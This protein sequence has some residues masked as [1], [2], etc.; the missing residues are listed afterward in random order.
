MQITENA[1]ETLIENLTT[2][3]T[4]TPDPAHPFMDP[5]K[6]AALTESMEAHGWV[7]APIVVDGDQALT[8][9]HRIRAA[10]AAW[11]DIPRIGVAELADAHGID[12]DALLDEHRRDWYRAAIA[13]AELLPAAV[14]DALGMDLH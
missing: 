12:W 3:R 4:S 8:G 2:V 10:A 14:V 7:G 1:T 11:V 6:L 5:A 13:L 9:A